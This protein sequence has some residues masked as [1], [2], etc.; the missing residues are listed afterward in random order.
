MK[1]VRIHAFGGPEVVALDEV[2]DPRPAAGEVGIAVRAAALNHVDID[3]REGL[4]RFPV[5]LPH[6]LGVEL[7]GE[8]D[9]LGAGVDGAWAIGDRVT[10]Y[11][12][13]AVFSQSGRGG[14]A[15]RV[16]WPA[17]RVVRL[18]DALSYEDAAAAGVVFA[19]ARHALLDRG[20]LQPGE[21][22]LVQS[23]GSG[24]GSAAAQ[25]AKLG[26]A[27]VI[28]TTSS[29]EKAARVRTLGLDAVL[30]RTTADVAAEVR[31][32][33]DGRGADLVFEHVGGA[34]FG[35]GLQALRPGGRIVVVG[36]HAGEE[37][38]VDLVAL[39]VV[40]QAIV[41][42]TRFERH[43][44]EAVLELVAAGRLRPLIHATFTLAEAREAI[45]EL[46][47]RRH[48]GKVLIVPG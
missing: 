37:V 41:G 39:F 40:E 29:P 26:G 16:V 34:S 24:L 28:G 27:T 44:L 5:R 1:A 20:A 43:D 2:D 38:P 22:V 18:P 8:I 45:E 7:V 32:L 12:Q 6:T 11:D 14:L 42:A 21:T 15:E 47:R 33:T 23:V 17:T 30:D 10:V 36:A 48:V 25:V 13:G 4:A 46:E 3:V 35:V 9:E 19:S 31:R